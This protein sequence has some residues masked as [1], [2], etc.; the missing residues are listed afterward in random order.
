[1][2]L[3]AV[4]VAVAIGDTSN[5]ARAATAYVRNAVHA[6]FSAVWSTGVAR[7]D[8]YAARSDGH[9]VVRDLLVET[10]LAV[11]IAAGWTAIGR[12][13]RHDRLAGVLR[14]TL[15]YLVGTVMLIYGGLKVV[16][17]QF[18]VPSAEE[19]LR[20]LG[21]RSSMALLWAFMGASP[22]YTVFAG[23]AEV[24]GGALLFWRRTTTLGALVLIGVLA[25]VVML[26]FT[27]DVPV[28]HGTALLFV[29]VLAL[30]SRDAGRLLRVLVLDPPTGSG[31]HAPFAAGP[32]LRL[33]RRIVKPTIVVLAVGGPIAA[34]V[35]LGAQPDGRGPL[36]GFYAV[37]RFLR[38]GTEVAPLRTDP[39]RWW[40]VVIGDR[41]GVVVE[42]A[43]GRCERF[44]SSVDE[45]EH[46]LTLQP[47]DDRPTLR[48]R[49]EL[50]ANQLRL[51]GDGRTGLEVVL[52]PV[53]VGTVFGVLR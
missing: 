35:V 40:R 32:R 49:Y 20:P 14:M 45:H 2:A 30:A 52:R 37:E 47:T 4:Q 28:K 11:A 36:D 5:E 43:S 48:F 9:A 41:G 27:Y 8:R 16:P 3:F 25:N 26:N 51:Q 29:A 50:A 13:R 53:P 6:A 38:D 21:E 12:A 42:N 19:L 10:A 31:G 34:A 46:T 22:S 7:L 15:R 39:T 18:P 17:V 24:L 44:R 23:L 33:V 1:M